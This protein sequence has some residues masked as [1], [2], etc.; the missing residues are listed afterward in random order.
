MADIKK[1][2][3]DKIVNPLLGILAVLTVVANQFSKGKVLPMV[4]ALC[5]VTL[6]FGVEIYRNYWRNRKRMAFH[7]TLG[8]LA[9][10]TIAFVFYCIT[11][12]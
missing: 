9:A 7:C 11:G 8:L 6:L 2:K 10:Y 4:F 5:F 12:T 1:Y 3:S